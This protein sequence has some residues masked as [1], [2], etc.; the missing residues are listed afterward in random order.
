[1]A[2]YRTNTPFV[3]VYRKE[4][5]SLTFVFSVASSVG[6]RSRQP[7]GNHANVAHPSPA[8]HTLHRNR[9]SGD[10]SGITSAVV[11]QN[12]SSFT[13]EQCHDVTR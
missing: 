2:I 12:L 1:M 4:S 6:A 9:M 5:R 7:T 8:D 11:M 10:T 13:F 3:N